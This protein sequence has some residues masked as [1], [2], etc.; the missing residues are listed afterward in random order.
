M[1]HYFNNLKGTTRKIYN[2][3]QIHIRNIKYIHFSVSTI[4]YKFVK[5][6]E[7]SQISKFLHAYQLRFKLC[8]LVS[9]DH[10]YGPRQVAFFDDI[11]KNLL[12]L[13]HTHTHTYIYIYLFIY[14]FINR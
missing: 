1:I 3:Q 11:I 10:T 13:T 4:L 5:V 6:C 2:K 7:I 14:L 8:I 12:R 9:G